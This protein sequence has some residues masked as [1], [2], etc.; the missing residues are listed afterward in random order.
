MVI[1]NRKTGQKFEV[2][3]MDFENKIVAKGL[4]GKYDVVEDNKPL[5]LKQLSVEF[6]KKKNQPKANGN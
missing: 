6:H 5:E 3:A 1:K 2:S 4:S